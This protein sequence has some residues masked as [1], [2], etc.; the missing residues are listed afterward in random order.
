MI[1]RQAL[2]FTVHMAAGIVFGALAIAACKAMKRRRD[3]HWRASPPPESA[4][5]TVEAR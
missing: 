5:E 2:N 3:D 4:E 1:I